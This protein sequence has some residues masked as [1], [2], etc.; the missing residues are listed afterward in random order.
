MKNFVFLS[1]NFPANY[2]LF[3]RELK[4]DGL[5]V[6]GIGDCPYPQLEPKLK[7]QLEEY[8]QVDSLEDYD[9]V[10]RAVAFFIHK[11]GRIDWLESNNEYWLE[12][13]A[14]LRTDFNICSG[15]KT[16]DMARVKYKSAMKA[17]YAAA[18]IPTA[19]Y[20]V[21]ENE[22]GCRAFIDEVGYPVVV[23][24]DNGV[25]ACQ[26]YKL[27]SDD[28]LNRFIRKHEH[29]STVFIMEEFVR[30]QICSYDAIIDGN[31]QPIFETGNITPLSIMD[32]VNNGDD[33]T[34][35]MRSKLP[36]D[37]VDAGR[38]AVHSFGV[39]SRFIHFE[40]FRLKEDMPSIGPAGTLAGLEVNM[41]PSGGC[42]PD[43]MNFAS[44]TDVY[45]IWADMIAYGHSTLHPEPAERFCAF[46]GRRDGKSYLRSDEN[47]LE[48]Y[49]DHL[50]LAGKVPDVLSDDM[51]NRMF[52]ANFDTEE[53]VYAYFR[54]L[55]ACKES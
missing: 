7:E 22:A 48:S 50:M 1:P 11:Y 43:M 3:C 16:E 49:G 34:F 15:F 32:M 29:D 39:K 20:Y 9:A 28:D 4:K 23:K 6:L 19:R 31:G 38:R 51:G 24:P 13:D 25:G 52:L 17:Q 18:S 14:W 5:R 12:R 41:R 54:E 53:E 36:D 2:W 10:Y 47:I 42:S 46:V 37:L 45:K 35:Y 40:F 55:T 8:Y 21:V 44:Q 27:N 26:T 30:G 33:C